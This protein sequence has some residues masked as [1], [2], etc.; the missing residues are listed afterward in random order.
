MIDRIRQ[1]FP[2]L[3]LAVYAYEPGQPVTAEAITPDGTR[4]SKTAPTAEAAFASIFG[5][6][7]DDQPETAIHNEGNAHEQAVDPFS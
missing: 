6:L 3:S 7:P 5:P 2:H 4:Y 1:L